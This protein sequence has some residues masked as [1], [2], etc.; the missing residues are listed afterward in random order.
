MAHLVCVEKDREPRIVP[1]K[2][3]LK[4]GRARDNDLVV[5]NMMMSR[6]HVHFE[7]A[8]NGWKIFDNGSTS[9]FLINDGL[10][11]SSRVLKDGDVIRFGGI[12]LTFVDG[13]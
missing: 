7:R 8:E 5:V 11:G 12:E 13:E 10:G 6:Y 9:G 3:P 4:I 2:H 1:L